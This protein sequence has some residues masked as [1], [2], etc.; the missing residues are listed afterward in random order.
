MAELLLPGVRPMGLG[1]SAHTGPAPRR[2][3]ITPDPVR[4]VPPLLAQRAVRQARNA[5]GRAPVTVEWALC[6]L[7]L[8]G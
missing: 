8:S 1:R 7:S 4:V 2:I 6:K 5:D 3:D